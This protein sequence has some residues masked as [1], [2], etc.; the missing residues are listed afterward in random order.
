MILML[1]DEADR[2]RR[3]TRALR[4]IDPGLTLRVWRDAH[5]MSREVAA[6]LPSARLISLDHDLEPLPGDPPDLGD[7]MVVARALALLPQPCPV[8]IHSSNGTRSDW[9]AGEFELGGWEYRRVAPIGERWIE[10]YWR[11]VVRELLAG[12][13]A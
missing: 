3:F 11:S 5:Q 1:E 12:R 6:E 13:H 7:G 9:M 4:S 8:I 10:E 2:I